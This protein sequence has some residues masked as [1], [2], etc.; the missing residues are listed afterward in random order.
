MESKAAS[1]Q[2]GE[3]STAISASSRSASG[4]PA[5]DAAGDEVA[6]L[7]LFVGDADGAHAPMRPTAGE[8][9]MMTKRRTRAPHSVDRS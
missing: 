4:V 6:P 3:P 9:R 7:V 5:S 1:G 2:S 8:T